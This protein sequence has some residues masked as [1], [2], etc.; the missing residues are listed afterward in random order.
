MCVCVV[1]FWVGAKGICVMFCGVS[2]GQSN[3]GTS[4]DFRTCIQGAMRPF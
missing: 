2:V 1:L 4:V 3:S